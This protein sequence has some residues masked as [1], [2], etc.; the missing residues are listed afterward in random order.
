MDLHGFW[1]LAFS[2]KR[3]FPFNSFI[4]NPFEVGSL[5]QLVSHWATNLWGRVR[6]LFVPKL[7]GC[8]IL[9]ASLLWSLAV[10][11]SL[12]RVAIRDVSPNSLTPIHSVRYVIVS[13]FPLPIFPSIFPVKAWSQ[14]P[15]AR[16]H[17]RSLRC[18]PLWGLCRCRGGSSNANV[19]LGLARL[20]LFPKASWIWAQKPQQYTRCDRFRPMPFPKPDQL[21]LNQVVLGAFLQRFYLGQLLL[22]FCVTGVFISLVSSLQTDTPKF[23]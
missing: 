5:P 1:S 23:R 3:R 17:C 4:S 19:E 9:F 10:L 22:L 12:S 18:A 2:Q 16:F 11:I 8:F 20:R 6:F 7:D 13:I 15:R 21:F 14:C